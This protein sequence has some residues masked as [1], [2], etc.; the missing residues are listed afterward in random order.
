MMRKLKLPSILTALFISLLSRHVTSFVVLRPSLLGSGKGPNQHGLSAETNQETC[1]YSMAFPPHRIDLTSPPASKKSFFSFPFSKNR[2]QPLA[3]RV[4]WHPQQDTLGALATLWR[5]A[6]NLETTSST[7][8]AAFP[9]A[10]PHVIHQWTEIFQWSVSK[11]NNPWADTFAP[12]VVYEYFDNQV[13]IVRMTPAQARPTTT[14]TTT[15]TLKNSINH[16]T[17]TRRTQAWVQRILVEQG[18]CPF[19]KSVRTSGQG[20]KDLGVSAARIDYRTSTS[21]MGTS[22]LADSVESMRDML[23]AGPSDVSSVLLAAPAF[24]DQW[25]YWSGPYFAILQATVTAAREEKQLG[26]VCFHPYYQI[27]D[28]STWPGFGQ[29]HSVP[30]LQSWCNE[31]PRSW[32]EAAAGG[33]WQRRTPHATLNLLRADQLAVAEARRDSSQLYPENI[34]KLVDGIGVERLQADLERERKLE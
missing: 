20:L 23:M 8:V 1:P 4:E 32:D 19:T 29:M 30:R 12:Q 13:P 34:A 21:C 26:V 28:G 15:N 25:L 27:P 6:S 11:D 31:A 3:D 9:D 7:V 2:L 5:I 24:D 33:A 14:G 18:I 22:L 16:D 17:V 10:Q